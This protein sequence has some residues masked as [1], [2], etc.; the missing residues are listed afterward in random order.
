MIT[1]HIVGGGVELHST[2]L[3]RSVPPGTEEKSIKTFNNIQ[4]MK[5]GYI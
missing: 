4:R 5:I 3:S 1:E 2:G